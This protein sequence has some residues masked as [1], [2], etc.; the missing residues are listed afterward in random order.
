MQIDSA[1]MSVNYDR[2]ADVLYLN[3]GDY[4]TNTIDIGDGI[5]VRVCPFS[6]EVLGF[7]LVGI[8]EKLNAISNNSRS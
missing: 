1:I 6:G 5:L 4:Y 3:A 2:E 7:T 8:G